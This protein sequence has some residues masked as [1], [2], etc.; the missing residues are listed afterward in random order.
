MHISTIV[1]CSHT[2]TVQ[3]IY[4]IYVEYAHLQKS[5]KKWGPQ[6]DAFDK[7]QTCDKKKHDKINS[8]RSKTHNHG[9][10]NSIQSYSSSIIQALKMIVILVK[11]SLATIELMI[12]IGIVMIVVIMRIKTAYTLMAISQFKS[13]A[14]M[15]LGDRKL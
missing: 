1:S 5:E 7:K 12:T 2:S 11:M 10:N 13:I 14:G 6:G 3:I 4:H 9:I 8:S 15:L